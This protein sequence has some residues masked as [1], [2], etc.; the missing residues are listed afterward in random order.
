MFIQVI[1]GKVVDGPGLRRFLDRWTEELRPGA[2]GY[3]GSISG[4][5]ED[6]T[7]ITL[8][9]FESEEA[10]R[11]NSERPEQDSWWFETKDCFDGPVSFMDCP[12]VTT[13]RGGGAADVGCRSWRAAPPTRGGSG[14]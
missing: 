4:I 1:R 3:P 6:G 13:W 5:R 2:V 14:S 7:F 11:R 12:Y 8:V 10:A 9:R